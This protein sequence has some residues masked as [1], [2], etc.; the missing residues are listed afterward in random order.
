M[1][2]RSN[3]AV[4]QHLW[5]SST[6]SW[7]SSPSGLT[8]VA[9]DAD[10]TLYFTHASDSY[11]SAVTATGLHVSYNLMTARA[12]QLGGLA[13]D[14]TTSSLYIADSLNHVIVRM[15]TSTGEQLAE[16]ATSEPPLDKPY[17]VAVDGV[18][19]RLYVADTGNSRVVVL[20]SV[21]GAQL[22]VY[23]TSEPALSLPMDV[24]LDAAGCMYVADAGNDRVVKLDGT[25][26]AVVGVFTA[27]GPSLSGPTGVALDA[28]GKLYIS[29][30][31]Q[32][33]HRGAESSTTLQLAVL[34]REQSRRCREPNGILVERG[35]PRVCC[36]HRQ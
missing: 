28:D 18:R 13:A 30:H 29:D 32:Q 4:L 36:R 19:Q 31:A 24:A 21:T 15:N 7:R 8:S 23:V 16:Y 17:G 33:P 25:S 20:D 11:I 9:L 26:G 12:S 27:S 14:P 10:G 6:A 34:E 2:H 5:H 1:L 3:P 22:A 35:S